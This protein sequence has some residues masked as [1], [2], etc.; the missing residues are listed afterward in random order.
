[1]KV[2]AKMLDDLVGRVNVTELIGAFLQ[3]RVATLDFS[4]FEKIIKWS[5]FIPEATQAQIGFMYEMFDKDC[6]G[7]I[8]IYEFVKAFEVCDDNIPSLLNNLL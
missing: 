8:D 2:A 6:N 1:M 7:V 3:F 5:Q 4:Q